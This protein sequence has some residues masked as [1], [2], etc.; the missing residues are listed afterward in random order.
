MII[1]LINHGVQFC[2]EQP[3]SHSMRTSRDSIGI[4]IGA[5]KHNEILK[6]TAF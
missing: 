1:I 6:L 2:G 5:F 4:E 3:D